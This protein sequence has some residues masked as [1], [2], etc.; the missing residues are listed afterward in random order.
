[1]KSDHHL[2][3]VCPSACYFH[4]TSYFG[5]LLKFVSTFQFWLKMDKSNGSFTL[6]LHTFII[7]RYEW[8]SFIRQ[9]SL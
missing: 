9:C 1:V 2:H 4:E 8:P 3:H 5:I 6:S 7:S